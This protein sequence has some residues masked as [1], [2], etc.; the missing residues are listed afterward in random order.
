MLHNYKIFYLNI[1]TFYNFINIQIF[2]KFS[3]Y[4][5]NCFFI[6]YIVLDVIFGGFTVKMSR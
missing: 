1:F 3:Y 2:I 5:I 6:H 4:F